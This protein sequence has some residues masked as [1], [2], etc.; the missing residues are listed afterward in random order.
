MLTNTKTS[1]VTTFSHFFSQNYSLKTHVP[2][3]LVGFSSSLLH[4]ESS[5]EKERLDVW[6][7]CALSNFILMRKEMHRPSDKTRISSIFYV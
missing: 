3:C 6:V 7:R 2:S 1:H 4:P 5:C